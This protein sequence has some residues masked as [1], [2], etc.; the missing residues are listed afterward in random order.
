MDH[1]TLVTVD[2]DRVD[3]ANL[4]MEGILDKTGQIPLNGAA[5]CFESA[6]CTESQ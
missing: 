4:P 5:L 2:D 1:I 3:I 6:R